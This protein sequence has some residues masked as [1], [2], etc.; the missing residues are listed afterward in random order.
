MEIAHQ[1]QGE[2][3]SSPTDDQQFREIARGYD[4]LCQDVVDYSVGH[5]PHVG[6]S[7]EGCVDRSFQM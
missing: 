5:I 1:E 3:K 7:A 6:L 2:G 4:V